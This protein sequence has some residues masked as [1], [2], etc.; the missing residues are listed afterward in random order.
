MQKEKDRL[1]ILLDEAWE[2]L[3]KVRGICIDIRDEL[4][5]QVKHKNV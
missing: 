2:H 4:K 5:K 1:E 3:S